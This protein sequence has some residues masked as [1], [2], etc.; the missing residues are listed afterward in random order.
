MTDKFIN[1]SRKGFGHTVKKYNKDD[2]FI[3]KVKNNENN[4]NKNNNDEKIKIKIIKK[5]IK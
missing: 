1:F 3:F 2:N 5:I 4:N